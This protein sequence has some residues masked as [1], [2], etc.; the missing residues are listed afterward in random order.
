MSK[1][2]KVPLGSTRD[3][4]DGTVLFHDHDIGYTNLHMLTYVDTDT[5]VHV[6]PVKSEF[7]QGIAS[8][9]TFRL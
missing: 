8:L 4:C 3:P 9:S 1:N 7:A 6:K 5:P 2:K